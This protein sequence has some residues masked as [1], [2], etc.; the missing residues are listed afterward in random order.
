MRVSRVREETHRLGR[1]EKDHFLQSLRILYTAFFP[2][3]T[4]VAKKKTTPVPNAKNLFPFLNDSGI[5]AAEIMCA[6]LLRRKNWS[7]THK[8]LFINP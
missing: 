3:L 6:P 2:L 8:T 1:K 7:V 4:I 5:H